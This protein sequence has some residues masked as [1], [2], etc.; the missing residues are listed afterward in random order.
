MNEVIQ[1]MSKE[2]KTMLS[3][4]MISLPSLPIFM[5]LKVF[6]SKKDY[7]L[8]DRM[9]AFSFGA[10]FGDTFFEVLP[11]LIEL[12]SDDH[13]KIHQSTIYIVIGFMAFFVF[14]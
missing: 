13:H 11:T 7:G 6:N 1:S 5:I 14:E 8:V 12:V 4:L 10:L 2:S 3:I 9:V